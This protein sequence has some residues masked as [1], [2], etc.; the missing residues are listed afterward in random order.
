[1]S[2]R[3]LVQRSRLHQKWLLKAISGAKPVEISKGI[4]YYSDMSRLRHKVPHGPGSLGRL[5]DTRKARG[6]S[7]H[8][9]ADLSGVP[10]ITISRAENGRG[11]HTTTVAKLAA[12]LGVEPGELM[13]PLEDER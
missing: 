10:V 11:V 13:T 6:L 4:R 9:L 2:T 1:M 3:F 8:D 7:Q 12:A 5:H